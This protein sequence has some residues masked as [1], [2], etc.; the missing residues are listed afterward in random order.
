MRSYT[1]DS[2]ELSCWECFENYGKMCHDAQNNN[3]YESS[4]WDTK[5]HGRCCPPDSE[6]EECTT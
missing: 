3:L 5:G 4:R 6:T 1:G 2:R